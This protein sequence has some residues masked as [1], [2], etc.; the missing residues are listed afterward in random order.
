M[1]RFAPSG[2]VDRWHPVRLDRFLRHLYLE[3][4]FPYLEQRPAEFPAK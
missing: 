1:R 4:P 2:R 3:Q